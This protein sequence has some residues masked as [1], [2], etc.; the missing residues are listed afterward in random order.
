MSVTPV[1]VFATGNESRGDDAL[2]PLLVRS[3]QLE[4]DFTQVEVLEDFQLQVE[5]TLDLM[6]R[7]LILF[8]DA[9]QRTVA[10]FTFYEAKPSPL[11]AHTTHAVAPESLLGGYQQV[12][13]YQPAPAFILCVSGESFELGEP[14][15]KAAHDH[16]KQAL[17]WVRSLIANPT[18]EY[19]RE[20]ADHCHSTEKFV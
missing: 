13:G 4:L 17:A 12:H 7:S 2:G 20:C 19:W 1:L 10:P 15:S 9:G 14:L 3:L 16:L 5:H 6:G 18:L 8:V 11:Q